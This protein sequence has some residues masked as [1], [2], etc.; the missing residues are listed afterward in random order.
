MNLVTLRTHNR[1]QAYRL[2]LQRVANQRQKN[3]KEQK[4]LN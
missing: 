4:Q 2:S 3:A 1:P